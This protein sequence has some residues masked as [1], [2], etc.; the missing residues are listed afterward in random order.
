MKI[1][2]PLDAA[3]SQIAA[4]E[5]TDSALAKYAPDLADI[6]EALPVE[7]LP[8]GLSQA[9]SALKTL[10]AGLGWSVRKREED[11]R[12]YMAD[13]LRDELRHVRGR[14]EQLDEE[15]RQFVHGEFWDLVLDGLQKAERTR[16]LSRITRIARI[17]ANATVDRPLKSSDETEET[18]RVAMDP[19]DDDIRVLA[20][21]VRGQKKS[22][23]EA[24][25]RVNQEAANNY[26]RSGIA[27]QL[28]DGKNPAARLGMSEGEMQ[29]HCAK[30]QAYGLIVQVPRNDMK[31]PLSIVPYSVLRRAVEFVD[32]IRS[33]AEQSERREGQ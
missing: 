25:G 21:L 31:L 18:M 30:L 1:D 10:T 12:R 26:W 11:R 5:R 14:L 7:L 28:T 23:D 16:S 27:E 32:A 19:D 33:V 17:L 20:E 13:T 2:D 4:E 22:L 6:A 15:Y 9:F 8:P 24:S 3:E 29:S